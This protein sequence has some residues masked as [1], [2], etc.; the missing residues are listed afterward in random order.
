MTW[1]LVALL[2]LLG[3]A[4]MSAWQFTP[5]RPEVSR[6]QAA[7]AEEPGQR[8]ALLR[9]AHACE[10]R[11]QE[12]ARLPMRRRGETVESRLRLLAVGEAAGISEFAASLATDPEVCR[13]DKL[14][15][16]QRGEELVAEAQLTLTAPPRLDHVAAQSDLAGSFG[17]PKWRELELSRPVLTN[18]YFER[19]TCV[20]DN[21]IC[22]AGQWVGKWRIESVLPDVVVIR[23]GETVIELHPT[24][25][26]SFIPKGGD[27]VR[28]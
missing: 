23:H 27:H 15:L 5:A 26:S 16:R 10:V 1:M 24:P 12:V 11:L 28:A 14:T 3:G 18:I 19:G 2:G 7:K 6:I 4:W 21:R 8:A 17:G 22:R 25:V 13:V 20:I 9:L